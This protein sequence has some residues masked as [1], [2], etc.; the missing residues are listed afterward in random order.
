M[1]IYQFRC[2]ECDDIIEILQSYFDERP[3]NHN[4]QHC[5]GKLL[6]IFSVPS[7]FIGGKTVGSVAEANAKKL[8]SDA[9]QHYID[10]IRTKKVR[11]HKR[12]MGDNPNLNKTRKTGDVAASKLKRRPE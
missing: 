12:D 3:T 2:E 6:Q 10:Q 11:T 5:N 1:P 8:S 4:H 7:S 9:K